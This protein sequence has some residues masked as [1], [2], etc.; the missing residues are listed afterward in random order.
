M[1]YAIA[2]ESGDRLKL[3]R[4]Y[5]YDIPKARNLIFAKAK[6]RK[7]SLLEVGTGRGHMALALAKKDIGLFQS[8]WI[9]KRKEQPGYP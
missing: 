6:L 8:I 7:G 1:G 5:G 9:E 4:K 3:F 2:R